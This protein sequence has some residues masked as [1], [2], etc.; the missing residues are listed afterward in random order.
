MR[1]TLPRLSRRDF[2]LA[3]TA[4][5]ALAGTGLAIRPASAAKIEHIHFLVPGGAGGGWDGTARGTGQALSEAGLIG[6]ASYENLSGAGGGK[7]IGH[8]IETA[9]RQ[10]DTLMVNSTPIVVRSLTKV[11]PYSFRDLTPIASIIADYGVIVA[12]PA[13]SY[14]DIGAVLAAFRDDPRSVKI[15]GGSV[16][17]DLDHLV[18]AMLFKAAGEDARKVAYI[19]YDAGGKAFAGLLSGETDLLSTGLGEVLQRHK[20]GEVRILALSAPARIDELP[21]VPTFA[22]ATGK[23]ISFAN[24]RGYFGVPGLPA[25]KAEAYAALFKELL[26]TP[27]WEAVR[28]R[29]GWTNLYQPLGEFVAFLERQEQ[30]I[31]DLMEELGFLQR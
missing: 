7:A 21:D 30:D 5:L 17:G 29:N 15:A 14:T 19:P 18:A 27:E 23:D 20:D 22:E 13:D 1:D 12:R 24:W 4:A 31:G 25:E 8:M 3:G 26:A 10:P 2:M 16:R 28:S 6:S 11:F 9:E